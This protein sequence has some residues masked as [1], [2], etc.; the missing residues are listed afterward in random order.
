MFAW[1]DGIQER[2]IELTSQRTAIAPGQSSLENKV[3]IREDQIESKEFS[4]VNYLGYSASLVQIGKR[5]LSRVRSRCFSTPGDTQTTIRSLSS[6]LSLRFKPLS[7]RAIASY[8]YVGHVCGLHLWVP[9]KV[10][11]SP[12][13]LPH[14]VEERRSCFMTKVLSYR[15]VNRIGLF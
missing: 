13:E 6:G 4:H 11:V 5:L 7:I 2:Y 9:L 10:Q 8:C 3:G 15:L 1:L 14:K 12:H